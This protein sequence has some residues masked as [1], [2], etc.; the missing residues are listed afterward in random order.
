MGFHQDLESMSV[1]EMPLMM[2]SKQCPSVD[3][4]DN[5]DAGSFTST[6]SSSSISSSSNTGGSN[7]DRQPQKRKVLQLP[8][9]WIYGALP[10][11]KEYGQWIRSQLSANPGDEH[12]GDCA[13]SRKQQQQARG[14]VMSRNINAQ[15]ENDP[16]KRLQH[17]LQGAIVGGIARV[18]NQ[19]HHHRSNDDDDSLFGIADDEKERATTTSLELTCLSSSS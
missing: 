8:P 1:M 16:W 19:R 18:T 3:P 11:D 12:D 15:E 14:S 9:E 2:G 6:S 4:D 10:T 5:D 13:S 17:D 7:S